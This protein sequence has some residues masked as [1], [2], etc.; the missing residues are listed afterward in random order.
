MKVK[1]T[2]IEGNTSYTHSKLNKLDSNV[3]SVAAKIDTIDKAFGAFKTVQKEKS[4]SEVLKP[5]YF[6]DSLLFSTYED[7][8]RFD[9]LLVDYDGDSAVYYVSCFSDIFYSAEYSRL[10]F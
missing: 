4:S 8:Q 6:P 3:A 5:D 1:I 2:A 7:L 9:E 10:T